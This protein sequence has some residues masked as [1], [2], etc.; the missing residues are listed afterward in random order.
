MGAPTSPP[1]P[2]RS[3]RPGA[4]GALLDMTQLGRSG[5]FGERPRAQ[6]ARDLLGVERLALEQRARERVQLLDV[7]LEDLPGARRAFE[8]DALDLTVDGERRL[9]AVVLRARD[10]PAEEDVLL[11]LA[12]GER[13]QLVGHAPLA[14]H[15]ARHLGGLLEVVAGTGRLLLQHDLLGGAAAHQ[16]GDAID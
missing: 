13:P 1:Y 2:Q 10:L 15:L 4:A 3:S 16:D 7:L 14:H 12:E 8:H 6:D 11:V 9:L 5:R